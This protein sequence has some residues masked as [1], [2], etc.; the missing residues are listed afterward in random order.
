MVSQ[1]I[2]DKWFSFPNLLLP[3]AAMVGIFLLAFNGLAYSVSPYLVVDKLTI[4]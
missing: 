2:F 4:W 1:Q 3:F